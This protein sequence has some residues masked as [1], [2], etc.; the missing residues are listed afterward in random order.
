MK[1]P[2]DP[3]GLNTMPLVACA[4]VVS[5]TTTETTATYGATEKVHPDWVKPTAQV[6]STPEPLSDRPNWLQS[7]IE[8][9][10]NS[11][12]GFGGKPMAKTRGITAIDAHAK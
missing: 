6:D 4:L 8:P 2:A 7:V 3:T 12:G 11:D 1:K 5:D 10:L 9:I